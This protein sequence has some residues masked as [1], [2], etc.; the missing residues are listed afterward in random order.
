MEIRHDEKISLAE[1]AVV[2]AA[3]MEIRKNGGVVWLKKKVIL[4][5]IVSVFRTN[6]QYVPV[7]DFLV[8]LHFPAGPF[9]GFLLHKEIGR[10]GLGVGDSQIAAVVINIRR[11]IEIVLELVS[12]FQS[13]VTAVVIRA[14]PRVIKHRGVLRRGISFLAV[15]ER[16]FQSE[17]LIINR[18]EKAP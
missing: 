14:Q 12:V 15:D 8:H 2:A 3:G 5:E 11:H 18:T 7:P 10:S 16:A 13:G 4:A 6:G 1:K 9:A 17:I